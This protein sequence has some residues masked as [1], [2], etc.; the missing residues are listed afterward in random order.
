ML[1][2]SRE[3]QVEIDQRGTLAEIRV[4]FETDPGAADLTA[5]LAARLRAAFQ[6]RIEVERVAAGSL[7][8][9]EFKARRWKILK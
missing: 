3:Y 6:I 2:R 5:E 4:R 7:P 9:F 8:V 1:F